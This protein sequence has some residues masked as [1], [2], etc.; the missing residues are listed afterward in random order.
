M[1]NDLSWLKP[2]RTF[3]K[4]KFPLLRENRKLVTRFLLTFLFIAI[5]VWFFKHE[6]SE[7]K[8]VGHVLITS[9]WQYIALGIGLTIIYIIAQGSMYTFAFAAVG[10]SIR[11]VPAT[12]LFLKR[13]FIS[14]FIPAGGVASLAF[15]TGDLEKEDTSKTKI[16]FASSIYVFVGIVSVVLVSIPIFLYAMFDGF[17]GNGEWLALGGMVAFVVAIYWAY[18]SVVG[19]GFLYRLL[20]RF[21]PSL[22]IILD[23]L[24]SHTISPRFLIYTFINSFIIDFV[25]IA[26]LYVAMLALN[27]QAD[28]F[29][30]MMGYV[31][32]VVLLFISPFMRGLGAVEVSLSYVLIRFGY[33]NVEAV[34]ITFL[35]RFFEFWF[36]LL[37]GA[38]S[39]L[40]KIN[41]LLIR[42]IPSFLIFIL[43]II[44]IVSVMTPAIHE[45]LH[46][47]QEFIPLDAIEASNYL[48][49]VAGA[50]L[51]LT[52]VYMLK[53]LR[54]A[55][56][57]ALL[58]SIVSFI[59]NVTKG[60]DYE[61]ATVAPGKASRI[62][63]NVSLFWEAPT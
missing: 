10:I 2:L 13:N 5:G 43:G 59:G 17:A 14:I 8:Q 36:P 15:F 34:A 48:V 49:L 63:L 33:T 60:I 25:C 55:W 45:R 35:Y 27:F 32:T 9:Q 44:N 29:Y 6:Q 54:N 53:G 40:L 19:K 57:I 16:L 42:I 28:I 23:D 61:E 22:V 1:A 56:W 26:L 62:P 52:A 24:Q 4:D 18:R 12:V 31:T 58:L 50:F 46:R 47:L 7:L 30:A 11:I 37:A 21:I 39:F 3:I 20:T 41:K 38:F 51:L